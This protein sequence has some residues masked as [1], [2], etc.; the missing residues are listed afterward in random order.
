MQTVAGLFETRAAAEDAIRRLQAAG[1]SAD[2]IGVAMKDTREAGEIAEATGAGDLSEEGATIGAVSGASVGALV[3][4]ALV[5]STLVLPGLGTFLIGGPLVAALTGA[6]IGAASGGLV[7]GLIGAGIPETDAQ[8]YASRLERGAHP[9][10]RPGP[11]GRGSPRPRDP[12]RR[13][14]PCRLSRQG[15]A[16]PRFLQADAPPTGAADLGKMG[17]GR[18]AG[19]S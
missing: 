15:R 8:D 5:G 10:L 19:A 3:G 17:R 7:G 4:L 13:R 1:F 11:R 12:H 2:R 16:D 9:R 18:P 14:R 6:G